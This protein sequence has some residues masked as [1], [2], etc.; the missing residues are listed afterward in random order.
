MRFAKGETVKYSEA[1]QK[2]E[3]V[4]LDASKPGEDKVV[5][6]PES[7]LRKPEEIRTGDL[8]FAVRVKGYYT[9]SSVRARTDG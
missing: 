6:I 8:P 9:N 3:L 2:T 5:S 1:P 4:F 7:F